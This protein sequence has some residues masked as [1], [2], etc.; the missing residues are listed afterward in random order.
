MTATSQFFAPDGLGELK[1]GVRYH[2]I[3]V[4]LKSGRVFLASFLPS[5]SAAL[6]AMQVE[7]FETAL[8][9]DRLV[10]C[11]DTLNLP[12]WLIDLGGEDFASF[13]QARPKGK[14]S[15]RDM[16]E[17]RLFHLQPLVERLDEVF[18]SDD[19]R[20]EI[21]R[22][23]RVSIPRQN[24][25]RF[26]RWLLV[27]LAFGRNVWALLPAFHRIGHSDR[28]NC[29]AAKLGRLSIDG[30]L[31]GFRV[32]ASMREKI[33]FAVD[34]FAVVGRPMIDVYRLAVTKVFGCRTAQGDDGS[35]SFVHP[36]GAPFPSQN[37]FRYWAEKLF[38]KNDLNRRVYGDHRNRHEILAPQGSYIAAVA[39]LMEKAEGDA[40]S[41][42]EHPTGFTAN[43]ASPKVYVVRLQCVTSG[44]GFGI[45]FS[46]GSETSEAYRCALFCA[47]IPKKKFC[48]LFGIEIDGPDWP[49]IGL[50]AMFTPDR[51][52]GSA[53]DVVEQLKKVVA[54]VELPPSYEPQSHGV[55][56]SGHPRDMH[57]AGAPT[58]EISR[59]NAVG[60]ARREIRQ[61]IARNKSASA[62]S[63]MTPEMRKAGVLP[64]PLGVWNYL[65][66]RGRND[67][68][69]ISFDDAVRMFLTPVKF[70]LED[71][72]F[73]LG[74]MPYGSMAATTA[75]TSANYSKRWHV[76]EVDGFALNMCVRHAWV[77][78]ENR[79]VEV[80]ALLKIRDDGEQ[81]YMSL[82]ELAAHGLAERRDRRRLDKNRPA[83][84]AAE[85]EAAERDSGIEP[86]AARRVRGQAKAKSGVAKREIQH[87]KH[88]SQP[89]R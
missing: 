19:V 5:Q 62:Q 24:E 55:V 82:N 44:V 28:D 89:K 33:E 75:L 36:E 60:L 66:A 38:G 14:Q 42:R 48:E 69:A 12:P 56:E 79:I 37:Q 70:K 43:H 74:K 39:N 61:M 86:H 51:G 21:N 72:K 34:K 77:T 30:G 31:H 22:C 29:P 4:S 81:L 63:R 58:H 84:R 1:R 11:E 2:R 71:G 73:Y 64:T 23:A 67:A 68:Q 20:R 45:G 49:C 80:D 50:M 46:H 88:S 76:V 27:Y 26:T 54:I 9:S 78:I 40:Y 57:V 53:A 85:M 3:H 83:A 32:D 13:D 52:S 65:D 6:H 25:T 17:L 7:D 15:L 41:T 87:L 18:A 8:L 10:R 59:L 47:A 16:V 35:T